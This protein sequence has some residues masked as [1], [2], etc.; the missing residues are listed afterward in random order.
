MRSNC[1]FITIQKQE[2]LTR[3]Q[4]RLI[5]E[6]VEDCK[7]A[8][9]PLFLEVMTFSPDDRYDRESK[10]FADTLPE[11]IRTISERL[12]GMGAEDFKTGISGEYSLRYG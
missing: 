4:E 1:W 10:E 9:L 12:G 6:V 11:V 5:E 7:Q 3:K 8:D 2:S